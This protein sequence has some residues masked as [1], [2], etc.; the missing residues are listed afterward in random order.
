MNR[1]KWA[2]QTP[3]RHF[4]RIETISIRNQVHYFRFHALADLDPEFDSLLRAAYA[5]GE[6]RHLRTRRSRRAGA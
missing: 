3:H 4:V 5:V 2:R 1:V 6:Q